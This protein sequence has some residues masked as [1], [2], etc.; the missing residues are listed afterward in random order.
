MVKPQ[1]D[2]GAADPAAEQ[3]FV[4]MTAGGGGKPAKEIYARPFEFEFRDI[5]TR[6][7]W[8]PSATA[9]GCGGSGSSTAS[10]RRCS[11]SS[12]SVCKAH[13]RVD[14]DI[15][16]KLQGKIL[17]R[18]GDGAPW[19]GRRVFAVDGAKMNLPR[20]LVERSYPTPNANA[21]YPQGLVSCLYRADRR[22]P[23]DFS[24]SADA[25]ERAAAKAIEEFMGAARTMRDVGSHTIPA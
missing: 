25:C 9:N 17:E 6:R 4:G 14:E 11:S 3:S 16:L 24:L 19:N 22:I 1:C 23:F 21:R 13:I 12:S 20:P 5:P 18:A 2:H 10:S 7:I 15:F 8:R